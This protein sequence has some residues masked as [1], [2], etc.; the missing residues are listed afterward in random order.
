MKYLIYLLL[1][2]AL[3]LTPELLSGQVQGQWKG[4][5]Q[6]NGQEYR[7]EVLLQKSGRKV[8]GT[9]FIYLSD[10]LLVQMEATGYWHDDRSMNLYDQILLY[11]PIDES[12]PQDEIPRRTYQLIYSRSFNDRIIE[13]WWQERD[14]G[15][16][17][18]DRKRGRIYLQKVSASKA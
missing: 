14:K 18:P 8:T 6:E 1:S 3:L 12:A 10:S 13:G 17:D 9:T 7:F 11:P 2:S 16:F 5:L 15:N 4:T